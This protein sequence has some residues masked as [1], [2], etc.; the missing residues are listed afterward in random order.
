MKIDF[1]FRD[2]M[3]GDFE[4]ISLLWETI[5][6]GDKKRG[7]NESVILKTIKSGGKFIL[8]LEKTTNN[9]IGTSWITN[10]YRRLYLHHF[11]IAKEFQGKGLS[12]PL[13]QESLLFA[14]TTGLQIKLE[15]HKNNKIACN[16]YEKYGFS[17][18]GDYLV[19]IIRDVH[20]ITSSGVIR[21]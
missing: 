20:T 6:L 5:G 2:Y 10:D 13:L 7:D 19:Y 12:K 17:Y 14:K 3:Y 18:L 15:V 8:M 21:K 9:L 11:G 16:L 4:K 1:Y